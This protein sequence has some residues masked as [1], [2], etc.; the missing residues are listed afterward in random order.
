MET[1]LNHYAKSYLVI[2][3]DDDGSERMMRQYGASVE[4]AVRPIEK[5]GTEI[6]AVLSDRRKPKRERPRK[7][8]LYRCPVCAN[9]VEGGENPIT[10]QAILDAG[11]K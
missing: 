3:K 8:Y 2:Y 9:E 7:G 4:D 5:S 1:K 6:L 11:R 10:A